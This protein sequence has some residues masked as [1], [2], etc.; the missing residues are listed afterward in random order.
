MTL[1]G[2]NIFLGVRLC[3]TFR[4]RPSC[5]VVS[6]RNDIRIGRNSPISLAHCTRWHLSVPVK[7]VPTNF[8]GRDGPCITNKDTILRD[9]D[10]ALGR[11]SPPN[12]EVILTEHIAHV[13][14]PLTRF[15][16]RTLLRFGHVAV[17]YT[18]SDGQQRVFNIMGDF[19]E[20]DASMVN[21][22]PPKEYMFGTAG[23][24]TFSQQG[25][26]YNRPFVGVRIERV[27]AGAIDAMHAYFIALDLKTR[28][29]PSTPETPNMSENEQPPGSEKR[30]AARFQ[31]VEARLSRISQHLPKSIS[32]FV[33]GAVKVLGNARRRRR[34]M[35][36]MPQS[37][38]TSI[39]DFRSVYN[40]AGNCA[41]WTSSGMQF[42]GLLRRNRLFPKAILVQ[43]LE[44]EV[45]NGRR[46]NVN[47]VY[48]KQVAHA[49]AKDE[50]YRYELPAYVHPLY[51]TRNT[52]YSD[53]TQFAS[54]V[55]SCPP[56]Q[57]TAEVQKRDPAKIRDPPQWL[58]AWS[59]AVV[60]MPALV[61][62]GA[63]DQ[64]GPLGPTAAAAWLGLN[65]WLY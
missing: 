57:V 18:T 15:L 54:A 11:D 53:M 22:V 44:S 41:Q 14:S 29:D 37:L 59:A 12:L 28:V 33:D 48:Y 16:H 65:W 45:W 9:I 26:V 3:G 4:K 58:R 62:I 8:G 13:S 52:V 5:R 31:L 10:I 34:D 51:L 1:S 20:P 50:N 25:G 32:R 6:C 43:L 24:D 30:G 55:V 38:K 19:D 49:T 63:M 60:G 47:V 40:E 21:F 64:I 23:F 42:C 61:L 2:R 7:N 35:P 17:R 56:G 46:D 36:D 39:R 27:A